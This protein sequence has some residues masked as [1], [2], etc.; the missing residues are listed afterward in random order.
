MRAYKL[1][2]LNLET[3]SQRRQSLCLK[4][5]K[6]GIKYDKLIDL[7]PLN[8]KVPEMKTR[9][10]D[11]YKANNA[12]TERLKTGSVITMQKYLNY[13]VLWRTIVICLP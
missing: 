10:C 9:K 6:S 1:W 13:I 12:N 8:N 4:F 3:L 7:L 2:Y 11:K 5:A